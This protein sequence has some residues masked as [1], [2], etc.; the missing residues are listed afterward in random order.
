MNHGIGDLTAQAPRT[1]GKALLYGRRALALLCP[2]CGKTHLFHPWKNVQCLSS[3]F[4][5]N[6]GCPLCG[7]A[8]EREPGYF[9][10]AIWGV[11][12]GVVALGGMALYFALRFWTEWSPLL[13]FC[14]T[15]LPA[16]FLSILLARHAKSFFLAM[17]H[18][19][20]PHVR[21]KHKP[22]NFD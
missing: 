14:L 20:D 2:T 7:Y 12:Y 3:W 15:V 9:L 13:I 19:C 10:L 4:T 6:D 17:D 11:N 1:F 5:P 21:H 8:F 22:K 18:F 16:P